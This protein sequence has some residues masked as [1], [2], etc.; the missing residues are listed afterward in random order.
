MYMM[1]N[2][3]WKLCFSVL[4]AALFFASCSS[5]PSR[6][7]EIYS[8]RQMGEN[9]LD[10]V[11]KTTD[12]GDYETALGL[13]AEACRLAISVDDPSLRV[14]TKLAEGNICYNLG[15]ADEAQDALDAALAEAEA[16]SQ[17]ELAAQTR[18]YL[19]RSALLTKKSSPDEVIAQV[20]QAIDVVKKDNLAT[21]LGWTVLGLAEKEKGAYAESEA[22]FKKAIDLYADENYL[23]Q[24]AYGWYLTASS[25]S[26]SGKYD[27]AVAALNEA[28]SFDRRA[29]NT[30]GLAS[31]WRALGDVYKKAGKTAE[32]QAAYTRAAEIYRSID[33]EAE[34]ADAERRKN[35]D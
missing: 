16:S 31:D 34:A 35:N 6:P 17:P 24:A 21:A 15:R 33:R 14:R 23:E 25:R 3:Y 28:L 22:S 10:L 30:W 5:A 26:M 13:L 11:N 20:K 8:A 27:A 7:A 2:K 12:R 18:I 1:I 32:F 9:Q 4:G 29:E 19:E